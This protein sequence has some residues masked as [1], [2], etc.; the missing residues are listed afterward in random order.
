[1]L[2]RRHF[3]ISSLFFNLTRDTPRSSLIADARAAMAV[4]LPGS[5]H[6]VPPPTPDTSYLRAVASSPALFIHCLDEGD[7]SVERVLQLN[8][9][10]VSS[11]ALTAIHISHLLV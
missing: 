7:S 10:L 1:M 9:N 11:A 5:V 8:R 4:C 3:G 6:D 2:V